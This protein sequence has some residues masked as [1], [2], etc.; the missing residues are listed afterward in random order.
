MKGWQYIIICLSVAASALGDDTGFKLPG[1]PCLLAA[2]SEQLLA[3]LRNHEVASEIKTKSR[4]LD[5]YSELQKITTRITR[6]FNYQYFRPLSQLVIN[7]ASDTEVW[8]AVLN[9]VTNFSRTTP[10]P[11][12]PTSFDDTLIIRSSSS[13]QGNEQRVLDV[14]LQYEPTGRIFRD[15]KGFFEKYFEQRSWSQRCTEVYNAMRMRYASGRWLDFPDPPDQVEVWY[16]LA[17]L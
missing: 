4:N 17:R 15:V 7:K 9:L 3:V 14:A 13:F 1:R 5:L 16:W 10:S 2:A 12:T 8:A 6:E 11:S